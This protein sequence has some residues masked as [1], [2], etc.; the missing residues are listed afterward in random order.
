MCIYCTSVILKFSILRI[1][2]K[3][4]VG[5]AKKALLTAESSLQVTTGSILTIQ[6]E[7]FSVVIIHDGAI[8]IMYDL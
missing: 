8:A 6:F 2:G 4:E 3:W 5:G 1:M 7:L